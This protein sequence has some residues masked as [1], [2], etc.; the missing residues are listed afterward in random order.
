MWTRTRKTILAVSFALVA[1]VASSLPV[2]AQSN[3]VSIRMEN[4]TGYNINQV[5]LSSV[6]ENSWR[7]DLLG[8]GYFYNGTAFTIIQ[9]TP[10]RYDMEFVDEDLDVCVLH[11]VAIFSNLR[12]NLT[13]Q[14][15]L[16]CER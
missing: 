1:I 9:I 7:R 14:W 12:W 10:G 15:L 4:N 11:D 13:Q 2:A 16:N 6:F 5:H 3:Y 8:S